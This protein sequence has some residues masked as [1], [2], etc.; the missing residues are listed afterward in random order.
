MATAE[1]SSGTAAAPRPSRPQLTPPQKQAIASA[2]GELICATIT[3][4]KPHF[5]DPTLAG[6][7]ETPLSGGFV[8][9]KRA[10]HLRACCGGLQGQAMTL[11]RA[12]YD[13][14]VRSAL[15][16][17]RFPPLSPTELP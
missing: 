10:K 5:P 2:T 9:L 11:G 12:V 7:A 16:D 13:A 1:L 15:E 17:V 4:R 6:S 14:A 8:S 3:G